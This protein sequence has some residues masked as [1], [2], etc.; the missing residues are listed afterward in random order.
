M[1]KL[2]CALSMALMLVS[3]SSCLDS[4]K[5]EISFEVNMLDNC[6]DG[7]ELYS[8]LGVYSVKIDTGTGLMD[9]SIRLK[10]AEG[11][12][13]TETVTIA[14]IPVTFANNCY[15][16][17]V[18]APQITSSGIVSIKSLTNLSGS[19][20]LL[21]GQFVNLRANY[22]INEMIRV[23]AHSQFF[24]YYNN[25]TACHG[26]ET[27]NTNETY[28]H[29]IIDGSAKTAQL[30]IEDAKF[31]Q[32]KQRYGLFQ[33]KKLSYVATTDGFIV[34]ADQ[35]IPVAD[36]VELTDKPVTNFKATLYNS[37]NA[38]ISFKFDDQYVDASCKELIN[39]N[40]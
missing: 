23:S 15:T 5:N 34:T 12:A 21:D 28:Y 16:F 27:F 9:L 19:F 18:A 4:G 33:L 1:K 35:V 7:A 29:L 30:E 14:S 6:Y 11:Q 39:S 20:Q 17:K 22:T 37:G 36:G 31:S 2:F 38:I 26:A 8:D 13:Q 40:N 25:Q 10:Y 32:D 3:M 24:N